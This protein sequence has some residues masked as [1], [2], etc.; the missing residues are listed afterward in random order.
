M[1]TAVF[2]GGCLTGPAHSAAELH[3]FLGYLVKCGITGR[4]YTIFGYKG[5]QVRDNIHASDLI[6]AMW[7]FA[8][9]PAPARVY[10][11]GGSRFAN[12]S[13]LEAIELSEKIARRKLDVTYS[14]QNRVG[15]HIWWVSDISRFQDDYPGFQLRY[16]IQRTLEEIHELGTSRWLADA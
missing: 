15:D 5:K 13:M 12:C 2:R 9:A 14:E 3:G 1:K 16:D 10:N 11:I 7:A 6:N 4:P 8:E